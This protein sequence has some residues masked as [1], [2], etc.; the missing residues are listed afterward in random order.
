M[1][2][3][4]ERLLV[5]LNHVLTLYPERRIEL[6]WKTPFQLFIAVQL[7][8]QTTDIQVNK[9]TSIFFDSIREP[10]DVIKLGLARFTQLVR[11]VN[12]FNNKARHIFASAQ[13]LVKTY[14]GRIPDTLDEIQKLP[15]VGI[16]TA[17]VILHQLY[18]LPMVGVDTHIH[19]VLNRVGIVK[20]TTP[21]ATDK[22]VER[23]F[24]TAQKDVA[25][26]A[27][28]LFGRYHCTARN[29]YC[30]GCGVQKVCRCITKMKYS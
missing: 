2:T 22:A 23:I 26:H 8:A 17:K 15:G 20:T 24:S 5:L 21:E 10:Q 14:D 11:R 29:P 4:R 28:V 19:R 30:D 13:M 7:S 18:G 12:Y 3:A 6:V 1:I 9:V 25:H 27:L 16:K